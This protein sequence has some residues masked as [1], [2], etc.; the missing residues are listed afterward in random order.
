MTYI[1]LVRH[2]AYENPK[3][4]FHGRS[5]GFPLSAQGHEQAKR[6]ASSMSHLPIHAIY[7]S[8][9]TRT[10]QTAQAIAYIHG[11]SIQTD[12]RLLDVKTPLQ[13]EP[14][15][16]LESINW[17][18]YRP[19][20]LA[21]G[22]ESLREMFRRIDSCIREKVAAHREQHIVFLSHGDPIMT[23]K[24]K[25]L[26]RPLRSRKP[27]YPYVPVAGGYIITIDDPWVVKS[28]RDLPT[29]NH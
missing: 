12:D 14:V 6:L 13:G 8:P 24:I 1:Y 7:T 17:N 20:F 28:V 21:R 9:L 4:I 26:G 15:S 5:P 25:Y 19:E 27:M 3:H 16:Y 18:F 22:G 29:D 11:L 2:A 10:Y 23:I